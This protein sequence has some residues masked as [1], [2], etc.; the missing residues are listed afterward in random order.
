MQYVLR[1]AMLVVVLSS[2]NTYKTKYPY[3]LDDFKPELRKQLEKI[4]ADGGHCL[5]TDDTV[6]RY[7]KD[8][9]P[10][11]VLIKMNKS[12]HPIL[13]AFAFTALIRKKA[14][15]LDNLLLK[16]LDDTAIVSYCAGEFGP[17]ETTVA[18]YI[19]DE[20]RGKTN[21]LKSDLIETVIVKHPYLIHAATFFLRE[22][23][24]NEKYY[25]PLKKIITNKYTWHY[26]YEE[27]LIGELSKYK[28]DNDTSFIAKILDINW[29]HKEKYKF[30][31]I[32][33]NPSEAY[34]FII[35]KQYNRL[36]KFDDQKLLQREF[37]RDNDFEIVFEQFINAAASYKSKKSAVVLSAILNKKL[38]PVFSED[39]KEDFRNF[40]FY[41]TLLNTI[42]KYKCGHYANL[43]AAIEPKAEVY[44]KKYALLPMEANIDFDL[45]ED[46]KT[47]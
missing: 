5:A 41:Y 40:H 38:Y 13:R 14:P 23:D 17:R 6:L 16:N 15:N 32:E 43:L 28:K 39:N 29:I 44:R 21:L 46:K 12:E 3:S 37:I 4:V 45:G 25:S 36:L 10:N 35:E 24:T 34:F 8:E 22:I 47:W 27:E 33:N 20:S 42:N 7:M 19:L 2:C 9:L 1:F 31:L 30:P 18:D 11:S 26:N